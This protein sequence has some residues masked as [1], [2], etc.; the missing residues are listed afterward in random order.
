AAHRN[1]RAARDVPEDD[2]EKHAAV[3]AY[4]KSRQVW[5]RLLVKTLR[6]RDRE[7]LAELPVA[8]QEVEERLQ[9]L[10]EEME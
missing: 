9:E 8:R 6:T 7:L 10:R 5:W 2:Q 4:A 1:L 3:L